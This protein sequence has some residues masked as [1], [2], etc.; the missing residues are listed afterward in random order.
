[1]K[2]TIIT[3]DLCDGKIYTRGKFVGAEGTIAIHVRELKWLEVPEW[4][5]RKYHICPNCIK[6]LRKMC[7]ERGVDDENA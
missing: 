5:R 6:K 3:C 4:V 1:M 2:S 7:M